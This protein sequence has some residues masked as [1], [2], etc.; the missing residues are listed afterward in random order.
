MKLE[1]KKIIGAV[2]PTLATA[3]GGPLAG[4]AVKTLSRAVLG[5]E[6]ATEAELD[7]ALANLTPEQSAAM[8]QA[9]IE[10]KRELARIDLRRDE[11][12][13]ED[14][15]SARSRDVAYVTAGQ[16]NTRGDV[17]AY[18]AIG[19][20]ALFIVLV[21]FKQIPDDGPTRDILFTLAGGVIALVKDVFGFEFGSSRGSEAKTDMLRETKR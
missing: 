3:L 14:R 6:D 12:V 20:L 17:L 4:M 8:Y 7:A 19:T 2:A 18:G 1:W 11:L 10:F 9:D 13:I 21:F 16:K 5:R 15:G